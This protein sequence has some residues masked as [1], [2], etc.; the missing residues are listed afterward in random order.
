MSS[1]STAYAEKT[2]SD[3]QDAAPKPA[4]QPEKG[5]A[6]L[7]RPGESTMMALMSAPANEPT[8]TPESSR[9][10]GSSRRPATRLRR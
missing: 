4:E 2:A 9:T 3:C 6:D 5:V 8:T 10:R 1:G 7:R